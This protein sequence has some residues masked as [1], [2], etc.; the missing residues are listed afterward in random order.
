MQWIGALWLLA[1]GGCDE[2]RDDVVRK[3]IGPAGGLVS[4][5]D[6]VLTLTFLPG[7]LSRDHEIVIF[8]SDEPPLVFGPAYRVKPDIELAV[9]VEVTYRRVLPSNTEGVAVAAIR[10]DDYTAQMGHWVPLP[11]LAIDVAS[12]AVLAADQELSL[13]YGMLEL[14]GSTSAGQDTDPTAGDTGD[15]TS[16]S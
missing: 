4:S 8:P 16:G 14:G 7:A 5:H 11:R 2:E 12:G 15:P 3:T 6:D 9:D 13:Y 1:A 10:R